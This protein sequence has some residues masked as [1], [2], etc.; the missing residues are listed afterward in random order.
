M[1]ISYPAIF[2]LNEDNLIEVTFPDIFGGVTC[3]EDIDDAINMAKDLLSIMYKTSPYQLSTPSNIDELKSRYKDV[4][5][6]LI[7]IEI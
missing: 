5:I 3:G 4:E 6:R 7:S 1:K 2:K